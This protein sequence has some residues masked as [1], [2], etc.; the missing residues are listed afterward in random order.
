[1]LGTVI[2]DRR[3]GRYSSMIPPLF[4]HGEYNHYHFGQFRETAKDDYG[5]NHG[6][7]GGGSDEITLSVT[8][9][10]ILMTVCMTT[11]G[12]MAGILRVIFFMNGRWL[13]VLPDYHAIPARYPAR[14]C[15]PMSTIT[16]T[17]NLLE[18]SQAQ[19]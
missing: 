5:E 2:S 19:S 6:R 9:F 4:I 7:K 13:K 10:I 1:M 14:L 11:A 18:R 16:L 3:N 12:H 17:H 8:S 15:A